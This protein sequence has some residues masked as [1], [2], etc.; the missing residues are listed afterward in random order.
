MAGPAGGDSGA[1]AL[2]AA[3][4]AG[5]LGEAA[6]LAAA[7]PPAA[8]RQV[9]HDWDSAAE[10]QLTRSL[11]RHLG[12]RLCGALRGGEAAR[13]AAALRL[14]QRIAGACPPATAA[15]LWS[16]AL[17]AHD[18]GDP[19]PGG[20]FTPLHLACWNTA[21]GGT[22]EGEALLRDLVTEAA[23]RCPEGLNIRKATALPSILR[24]SA[25]LGF[26]G[27][28]S[29]PETPLFVAARVGNAAAVRQ[30]LAAGADPRATCVGGPFGEALTP[31][32]AAERSGQP[33]LAA[34]LRA[35][36]AA[37]GEGGAAVPAAAA[38][39]GAATPPARSGGRRPR[40]TN[41]PTPPAARRR[42]PVAAP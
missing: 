29:S 27:G 40:G 34:L 4:A 33:E 3:L 15:R 14:I 1:A 18:K 22:A 10:R 39:P 28:G 31:G 35:P 17:L 23:R 11:G 42:R 7:A 5:D 13:A 12:R 16:D 38:A 24:G 32:A 21:L 6:A 19:A 30:L 26:P 41:S 9:Q 8:L 20:G 25:V 36:P 37:Q 2:A